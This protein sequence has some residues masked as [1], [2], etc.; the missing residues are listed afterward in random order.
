MSEI[1]RLIRVAARRNSSEEYT[2]MR[3]RALRSLVDRFR[4]KTMEE[5]VSGNVVLEAFL[6]GYLDSHPAVLAMVDQWLRECGEEPEPRTPRLSR[7]DLDEIY[8]AASRG[9]I[10]EEERDG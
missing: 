3:F 5:G 8:A 1:R 10:G 7:S 6:R 9:M 2:V 4:R